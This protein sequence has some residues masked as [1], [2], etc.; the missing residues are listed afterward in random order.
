MRSAIEIAS[1]GYEGAL[2][3]ISHDRHLLRTA[4]DDFYLVYQKKVQPFKRR[5][6]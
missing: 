1:S 5:L 2:I 4:V 3:L 6:G